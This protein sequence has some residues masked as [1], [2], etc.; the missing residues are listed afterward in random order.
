MFLI[1]TSAVTFGGLIAWLVIDHRRNKR[2]NREHERINRERMADGQPPLSRK[3]LGLDEN[4][5]F[6]QR[7]SKCGIPEEEKE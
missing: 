5:I 4:V 7:Q 3:E 2:I 1:I 6:N